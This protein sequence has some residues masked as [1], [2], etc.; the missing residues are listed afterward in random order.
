MS[1]A[2]FDYLIFFFDSVLA[3]FYF[4]ILLFSAVY[5]FV[6]SDKS[7]KICPR[8]KKELNQILPQLTNT[9]KST[10]NF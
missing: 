1:K 10:E 8:Q 5:I 9:N 7:T 4:F 2:E 6:K 3:N